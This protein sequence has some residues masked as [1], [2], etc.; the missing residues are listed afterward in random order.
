MTT[1][2][3]LLLGRERKAYPLQQGHTLRAIGQESGIDVVTTISPDDGCKTLGAV[4]PLKRAASGVRRMSTTTIQEKLLRETTSVIDTK[5]LIPPGTTRDFTLPKGSVIVE[6]EGD[7][8]NSTL[9]RYP[10]GDCPT[11]NSGALRVK[12]R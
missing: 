2:V 10:Y 8:I 7:D 1:T 4:V 6:Y 5:T 9:V 3:T 11:K 12:V